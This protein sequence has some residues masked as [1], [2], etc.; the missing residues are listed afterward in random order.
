MARR[1]ANQRGRPEHAR[2]F[3]TSKQAKT[4][5]CVIHAAKSGKRH[6][7]IGI[8]VQTSQKR[9]AFAQPLPAGMHGMLAPCMHQTTVITAA[10][11]MAATPHPDAWAVLLYQCDMNTP[12]LVFQE[13]ILER[14]VR[15]GGVRQSGCGSM[16]SPH[17]PSPSTTLVDAC[18]RV[19]QGALCLRVCARQKPTHI[20]S[21]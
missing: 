14:G 9:E 2:Q 11:P 8:V 10:V 7:H 13:A 4:R 3:Q 1:K 6:T 18:R 16:P 17:N 15:K 21:R 19:C 20:C 12:V 5:I